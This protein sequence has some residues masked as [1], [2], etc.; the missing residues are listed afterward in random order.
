MLE[1]GR[2]EAPQSIKHVD[3]VTYIGKPMSLG[4]MDRDSH[5]AVTMHIV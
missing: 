1:L 2:A 4:D 5:T 3:S